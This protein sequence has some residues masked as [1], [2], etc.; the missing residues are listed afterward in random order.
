MSLLKWET[1]KRKKKK[2]I[3][4]VLF[5]HL[6]IIVCNWTVSTIILIYFN[7][8]VINLF[9]FR[10]W[11]TL[12]NWWV[13]AIFPVSVYSAVSK[14]KLHFIITT[15]LILFVVLGSGITPKSGLGLCT[16]CSYYRMQNSLDFLRL[17]IEIWK[18]FSGRY[19]VVQHAPGMHI[20][21]WLWENLGVQSSTKMVLDSKMSGWKC[22]KSDA[23]EQP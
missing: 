7:K 10:L 23:T 8:N 1:R 22:E 11:I 20:Y 9:Y 6:S 15:K 21:S 12:R 14:L 2:H 3:S 18:Q 5:Q 4:L 19:Q 17:K 13:K 16:L